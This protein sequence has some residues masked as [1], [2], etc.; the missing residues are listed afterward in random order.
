M[1]LGTKTEFDGEYEQQLSDRFYIWE[2]NVSTGGITIIFVIVLIA[3]HRLGAFQTQ[4]VKR[5]NFRNVAFEKPQD[6][7]RRPT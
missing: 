3:V 5:P 4:L 1:E 6:E 7:T 2:S